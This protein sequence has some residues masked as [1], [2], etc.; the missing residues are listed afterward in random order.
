MEACILAMK[1][2][3]DRSTVQLRIDALHRDCALLVGLAFRAEPGAE[4]QHSSKV[5][6]RGTRKDEYSKLKLGER[7]NQ[8]GTTRQFAFCRA[9]PLRYHGLGEGMRLMA[10]LW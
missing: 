4:E 9:P 5:S 7:M 3:I 10:P 1:R 8:L 6:V 2:H